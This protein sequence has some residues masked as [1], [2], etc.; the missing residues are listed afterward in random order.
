MAELIKLAQA[1]IKQIKLCEEVGV[2][3]VSVKDSPQLGDNINSLEGLINGLK[4][5]FRH[6]DGQQRSMV[7][8]RLLNQPISK[9]KKSA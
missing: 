7:L 3:V 1:L 8:I 5:V 6:T 2:K 9:S 4:A